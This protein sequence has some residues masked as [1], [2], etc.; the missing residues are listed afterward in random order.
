MIQQQMARRQSADQNPV[1]D[2]RYGIDLQVL[3]NDDE[4]ALHRVESVSEARPS[5]R[6][7]LA[8]GA[9]AYARASDTLS[10]IEENYLH[11]VRDHQRQH[12][13]SRNYVRRDPRF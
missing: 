4:C 1:I 2:D 3:T 10:N 13:G 9:L 8:N 6:A 7:W 5:G 11:D 12:Q